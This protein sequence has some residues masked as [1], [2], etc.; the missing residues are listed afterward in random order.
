[1]AELDALK[2][3]V[4]DDSRHIQTLVGEVLKAVGMDVRTCGDGESALLMMRTWKPDIVLVDFEM[5]PMTGAEFTRALRRSE[6]DW[7]RHTPVLMMTAHGD[8]AHV[9]Q[10]RDAGV[11]GMI[12]KPL[13]TGA[14][15]AR[16]QGVLDRAATQ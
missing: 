11:D 13:S 9:L 16:V 7:N 10:A 12:A 2:A 8:Q 3:L 1:M 6:K 5:R 4:I 15:L 14:I